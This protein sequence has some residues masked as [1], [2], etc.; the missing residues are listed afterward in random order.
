MLERVWRQI[1][2]LFSAQYINIGIHEFNFALSSFLDIKRSLDIPLLIKDYTTELYSQYFTTPCN[3]SVL[4]VR[5]CTLTFMTS[6]WFGAAKFNIIYFF[7]KGLPIRNDLY[8]WWEYPLDVISS[9]S[10]FKKILTSQPKEYNISTWIKF[11]WCK[12]Q[13]FFYL[14]FFVT[15]VHVNNYVINI[16]IEIE[17]LILIHIHKSLNS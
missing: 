7:V 12:W 4:H 9:Q 14:S 2:V 8:K 17:I 1:A 3:V 15:K 13:A 10:I 6:P 11:Y 16:I 5:T